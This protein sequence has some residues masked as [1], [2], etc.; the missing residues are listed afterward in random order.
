MSEIIYDFTGNPFVDA[1]IWALSQ[2]VGKNPDEI[3]KDDL[4]EIAEDMF[5]TVYSNERWYRSILHGMVFPN[6]K[7]SNPG[8]FKK[9]IP[10]RKQK[11]LDYFNDSI[12]VIEPLG[13]SGSCVACGRREFNKRFFKSEIPLTGSGQML[14]YFSYYTKGADYCPA[15]AFAVQFSPLIMYKCGDLLLFHSDSKSLMKIWSKKAI[16][17]LKRQFLAGNIQGCF[18]EEYKN[19][20]NALFHMIGIIIDEMG[21]RGISDKQVSITFYRFKNFNKGA[22]LDIYYF[23]TVVFNFLTDIKR[24]ENYNDWMKI[25][26]KGYWKKPKDENEYK[27]NPNKVYNDL[28]DGKS[29]IPFFIGRKNREAI[30][31][32]NLMSHY[33]VEVMNMDEKRIEAIKEIGDKLA[34]YIR[35]TEDLKT[36]RNL[37]NATRYDS[38]RNILRIIIKKRI[39]NGEKEPLF[40]FEEYVT[41]LFPESSSG[42]KETQDLLLFRIYEILTEWMATTEFSNDLIINEEVSMEE[43]NV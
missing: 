9:S 31:G 40:S 12:E 5:D 38:F 23:P 6:G 43:E 22:N 2:W 34:S 16:N 3:D 14:N 27:N 29:I 36:L 41:Y 35:Q 1:G 4:K 10:E 33:L 28:L 13:S 17:N 11:A 8:D 7:I 30:G 39:K 20:K 19:V 21:I 32:W 18:N 24:H 25:V 26:I 15:C 42:W 37:E